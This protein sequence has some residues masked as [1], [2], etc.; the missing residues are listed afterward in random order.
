M[1]TPFPNK[2]RKE[3][4][5]TLLKVMG[6]AQV[7]VSFQGGG[8]SG[9]VNDV[10]LYNADND[11]ISLGNAVF[12]WEDTSSYFDHDANTWKSKTV[13]QEM[14]VHDILAKI[15]EDCLEQTDLDWCNNDGGQ[16]NLLIDLTT[17]PPS[18]ELNVGINYTHTEDHTFDFTYD[19]E[20]E[21]EEN[22]RTA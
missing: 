11:E 10:G 17:T 9:E 13:V 5:M 12:E 18:I 6:G 1:K 7:I 22:E 8:D 19:D 21:E 20:G 4:L 2:D 15:A 3:L 16:G 14:P